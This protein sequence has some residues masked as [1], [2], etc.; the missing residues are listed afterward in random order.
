[1]LF[2]KKNF[3][4]SSKRSALR[5]GIIFCIALQNLAAQE[6]LSYVSFVQQKGWFRLADGNK[7]STIHV[8]SFDYPG[9]LKVAEIFREDI[10]MV[11]HLKPDI[12]KDGIPKGE[13][14]L[15]IGSLDKNPFIQELVNNKKLDTS[16]L[17]RRREKFII[18]TIKNPFPEVKEALVIVGSDKRGTMYGMFDL[19]QQMG[20]SPWYWWADVPVATHTTVYIE[21][22]LHTMGEPVVRY[23]G[24][25][26]NDE[27]PALSG[28]AQEKFGG[29]NHVFYEKVFELL[30]R[31]KANYL[32]PAMWGNA[33]NDD[34]TLNPRL[35]DEYGIIM[36]TSHHEPM[37]R[38]QQE[39]KRYGKGEWNYEKNDSVLR[40]FWRNGIR[41]MGSH[42]SIVTIG[43]RGDGD[44]PMTEES[45]IALLQRIVHDQRNILHEI[46]GKDPSQIPQLWALYKEV[47]EYYEKGMNVPEDV[48][49]LLCD[50]NWGNIRLLPKQDEKPRT[51]GYG[52]YYHFD[53]VG[54]PRNYKWLN[55]NQVSRIWEQ[56]HLAYE[57]GVDRIWIVNVGDIK[58]MELPISFFMDY[59]WS[60]ANW[61]VERMQ[62]YTESWAKQQFGPDNA[63]TIAHILNQYTTFNSRRKPELLSPETYSLINFHEAD[64]IVTSYNE[65][66]ELAEKIYN[67]LPQNYRD[68]FY[69]LVLYPVKSCSNLTNI[70]VTAAKNKLYAMQGRTLTNELATH[71]EE[72]FSKDADLS[73]EYNTVLSHGKWNHMMDQTHIGYTYWQQPVENK[74]P[75][76]QRISI[77]PA[78]SPAMAT[79]GSARYRTNDSII[80]TTEK[81]DP[82]NK[83]NYSF[84]LFNR[85]KGSYSFSISS[86][87][88]WMQAI[89]AQGKIDDEMKIFIHIDW[90]LLPKEIHSGHLKIHTSC[91]TNF[92]L[93]VPIFDQAYPAPE[94]MHGFIESGGY[95]SIEA[96][97]FS[98]KVETPPFNWISIPEFGR[99]LSGMT[100]FPVKWKEM[101][102]LGTSPHLEYNMYLFH[103]SDI[104]I[105][106]YLSPTQNFLAGN[107][108]RYAIAIDDNKPVIVNIHADQSLAA[109]EKTVADNINITTSTISLDKPGNHMLKFWALD[110]G[111]VLQKI[112]VETGK[113]GESYLGPPESYHNE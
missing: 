58:P 104:Q 83:N 26:I 27:A 22:G 31:L 71:V 106:V 54:G 10:N 66:A 109:W 72:L 20:V 40:E 68:A 81:P 64:R 53:Y 6:S 108:L 25:F 60:P 100:L 105:H 36:G 50:D 7:V 44:M 74:M 67:K 12:S 113:I 13:Q 103:I 35:A 78:P 48:T 32:W 9:V 29:F 111:I 5:L 98:R 15:L 87:A 18:C 42:E 84:E 93:A 2:D 110:P 75:Q 51:G 73:R 99:T 4:L 63:T 19:S 79:E 86:D 61:P 11:L 102:P 33:F 94:S 92:E 24:F 46:T 8:S 82:W 52:I 70:Y 85:G 3:Q 34:D 21:P 39:W 65:L 77:L 89:P 28:W 41:H 45:N 1:M 97:H 62:K 90:N 101:L 112:V 43:M 17:F 69:Q 107:G 96:E 38:A 91:G 95:I 37:L 47:Q 88:P 56:M 76:V 49:L 14:I 16:G 59:A 57:Y 80:T 23:R 55:T 30:L